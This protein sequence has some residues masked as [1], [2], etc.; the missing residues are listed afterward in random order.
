[1]NA[2]IWFRNLRGRGEVEDPGLYRRIMN[3][4]EMER[5]LVDEIQLAQDRHK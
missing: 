5:E 3:I 2:D 1:M 4:I